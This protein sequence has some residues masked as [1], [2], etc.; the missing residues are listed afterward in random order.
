MK[1]R[2]HLHLFQIAIKSSH[3]SC[4]CIFATAYSMPWA[5]KWIRLPVRTR[6]CTSELSNGYCILRSLVGIFLHEAQQALLVG[7]GVFFAQ[8]PS[9]LHFSTC[10]AQD[11]FS[12]LSQNV[13]N[14]FSERPLNKR[15]SQRC[16]CTLVCWWTDTAS[17]RRADM[18]LANYKRHCSPGQGRF[19]PEPCSAHSRGICD[20]TDVGCTC[21]TRCTRSVLAWRIELFLVSECLL[22]D[23]VLRGRNHAKNCICADVFL[24]RGTCGDLRVQIWFCG[25]KCQSGNWAFCVSSALLLESCSSPYGCYWSRQMRNIAQCHWTWP[26]QC[27]VNQWERYGVSGIQSVNDKMFFRDD[28]RGEVQ[29]ITIVS[30]NTNV[31][32]TFYLSLVCHWHTHHNYVM[33]LKRWE[34]GWILEFTG[35]AFV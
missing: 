8:F 4:W 25:T 5:R 30:T 3:F 24:R 31:H 2:Y 7:D 17:A 1:S 21:T 32:T 33:Q 14:I 6:L 28:K 9:F 19:Y 11:E 10:V 20:T 15:F 18:M 27:S 23:P 35:R 16:P 26:W 29:F 12:R 13:V 22:W 34:C